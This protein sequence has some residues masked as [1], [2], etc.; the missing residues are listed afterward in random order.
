MFNFCQATWQS[1]RT[2]AFCLSTFK[3]AHR[4]TG[5][6]LLE[7]AS[8]LRKK[9]LSPCVKTWNRAVRSTANRRRQKE[10]RTLIGIVGPE[11]VP[12][13]SLAGQG[14]LS[15]SITEPNAP[16]LGEQPPN[17]LHPF[18]KLLIVFEP[19]PHPPRNME[20]AGNVAP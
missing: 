18:F 15:E 5:L 16:Y 1:W 19:L 14:P 17:S 4:H 6:W 20:E 11:C 3:K 8:F 10:P 2:N 12:V 13:K 7:M 9:T